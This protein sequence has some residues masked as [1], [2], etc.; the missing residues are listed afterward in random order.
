MKTQELLSQRGLQKVGVIQSLWSGYGEIARY[1]RRH[2]NDTVVVK[3]VI[4]PDDVHHPRGWN[5]QTGHNRKVDSYHNEANFYQNF[6]QYCQDKCK[7][8]RCIDLVSNLGMP[9]L[10]M[11]DLDATGFSLRRKSASSEDIQACLSWLAHFHG[12]FFT[13]STQSLWPVG[14]YW[15]LATRKDELEAMEPGELKNMAATIDNRLNLAKYQTLLH[16]DAKLANFCFSA[17]LS[18]DGKSKVAA[19]DF[20]YVGRGVGVKDLAYFLGSC[21]TEDALFELEEALLTSY[22]QYLR[23]ATSEYAPELD[24][25]QLEAEWRELY[26]FAWADFYRFLAGWSPEHAKINSYMK[27]QLELALTR[28]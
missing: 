5:T 11:E 1:Q 18:V 20:Q 27:Q 13:V 14:T 10:I 25:S 15:H 19:V 2:E 22:F 17:D 7:V 12:R 16:G 23:E 3:Q 24:F 9:L 8:P 26:C 6:A 28:I 21:L 4:L